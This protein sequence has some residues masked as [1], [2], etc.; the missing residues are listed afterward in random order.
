M[1]SLVDVHVLR[2]FCEGSVA[3]GW[4]W[5]LCATQQCSKDGQALISIA[6]FAVYMIFNDSC[7]WIGTP[8]RVWRQHD[9]PN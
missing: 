7:T 5:G 3:D 9:S 1:C 2:A 4:I 6:F 8:R